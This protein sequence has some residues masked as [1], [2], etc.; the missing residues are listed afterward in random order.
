MDSKYLLNQF[1]NLHGK[2]VYRNDVVNLLEKVRES[3]SRELKDVEKRLS[4]MVQHIKPGERLKIKL[5]K[6][7]KLEKVKPVKVTK[8]KAR[9]PP[10]KKS[11]SAPPVLPTSGVPQ[12]KNKVS[13]L[14][15]VV[16][17]ADI[18]NLNFSQVKLTGR[19]KDDFIRMYCDTQIMIW[20]KPGHGKT[21]YTLQFAQYLAE[22]GLL[23]LFVANEE[24]NRSTLTEK[25]RKFN[26]HH[27]NLS[28]VRKL[29]EL[30]ISNKTLDDFDVVFFDS[31]QSLKM[32]LDSYENFVEN[33]PGKM[34][35]IIVQTTKDGHFKGGQEWLHAVDIGGEIINRRMVLYKNRL[36]S[37]FDKKSDKL[38]FEQKV[39]DAKKRL[40]VKDEVKKLTAPKQTET[41]TVIYL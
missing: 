18:S 29:E 31:I 12:V 11:L 23:V 9:K 2:K 20:G 8:T 41:K 32:T 28:F 22:L 6:K 4:N 36:D 13:K 7:A 14:S 30:K 5:V 35:V 33:H 3:N 38:I 25:T 24:L 34:Y 16:S 1:N 39:I 10:V 17:G 37:E 26:I 19:F 21:V 40:S 15:G 27:K